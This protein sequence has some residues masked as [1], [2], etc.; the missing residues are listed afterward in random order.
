[1]QRHAFVLIF[2]DRAYDNQIP[3]S[4]FTDYRLPGW[5]HELVT[6]AEGGPSFDTFRAEAV[7]ALTA[8][9]RVDHDILTNSAD[10][11]RV[12]LLLTHWGLTI[13][14]LLG[15]SIAAIRS[16]ILRHDPTKSCR[17]KLHIN[18][19]IWWFTARHNLVDFFISKNKETIFIDI[20]VRVDGHWCPTHFVIIR[21]QCCRRSCNTWIYHLSVWCLQLPQI[22]NGYWVKNLYL[23]LYF[24]F[25]IPIN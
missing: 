13:K 8:F 4:V 7:L 6:R 3:F 1:M 5:V 10:K 15:Y 12:K 23:N 16:I 21:Q 14:R 20:S 18:F 24:T 9:F 11:M 22:W 25:L 2:T 19:F 17:V